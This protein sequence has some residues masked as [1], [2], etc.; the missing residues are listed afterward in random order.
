MLNNSSAPVEIERKYI[1]KMPSLEILRAQTGYTKSEI[2]QI[3]LPS[4]KGETHRI[5]RRVYADRTVYYETRK[6][7]IDKM[8]SHEDE[9][10]ISAAYF[11]ELSK[12]PLLG[13]LSIEK[14]RHTFIYSGQLFE[15]DIY[16]EWKNT[17]IMETELSDREKRVEM[18][19]FIEI[20]REVTG[21]KAYSN[22]SMSKSFPPEDVF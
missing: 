21:D 10:E 17:A 1:I 16:P 3:Y 22:A 9:R 11:C 7:R 8:S 14:V 19:P 18:P 15:I 2:L 4:E 13:T 6:I 5:R 12:N 20:V